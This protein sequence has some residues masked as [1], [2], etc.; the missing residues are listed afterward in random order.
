MLAP[1]RAYSP[2]STLASEMRTDHG[3]P[4]DAA[5]SRSTTEDCSARRNRKSTGS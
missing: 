4:P 5:P 2:S 1:M 3:G